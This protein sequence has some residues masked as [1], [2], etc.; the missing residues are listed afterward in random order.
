MAQGSNDG[1]KTWLEIACFKDE[2]FE[3]L[4]QRCLFTIGNGFAFSLYRLSISANNGDA[5]QVHVSELELLG[6]PTATI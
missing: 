2:E 4:N 5:Q 1:G 6:R 3:Q